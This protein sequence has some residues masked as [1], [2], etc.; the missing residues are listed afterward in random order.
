MADDADRAQA[1]IEQ[2]LEQALARRETT[3]Q[4]TGLCHWCE[5]VVPDTALFCD[6]HCAADWQRHVQARARNGKGT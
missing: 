4:P 2:N 6:E 5:E 1:Q 3:L